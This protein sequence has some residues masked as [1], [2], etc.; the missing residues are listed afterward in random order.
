MIS[1]D[2]EVERFQ[3]VAEMLHSP[4]D[5]QQLSI[6]GTVFLLGGVELLGKE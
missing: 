2:D 3:R 5:S 4:V 1:E 6:V